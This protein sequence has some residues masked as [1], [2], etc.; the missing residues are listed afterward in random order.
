MAK[1]KIILQRNKF[2]T[3]ADVARFA[4]VSVRTI[5]RWTDSGKL[6]E[7]RDESGRRIYDLFA[8]L[9]AKELAKRK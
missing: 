2:L 4:G 9:K 6:P 8:L 5:Q 7:W 1:E 3:P